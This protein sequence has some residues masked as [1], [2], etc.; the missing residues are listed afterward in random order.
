VEAC[1]LGSGGG[2]ASG[3]GRRRATTRSG[4]EKVANREIRVWDFE[5]ENGY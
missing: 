4:D 1:P 2:D 5:I 3:S